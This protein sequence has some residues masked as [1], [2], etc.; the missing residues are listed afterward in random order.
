MLRFVAIEGEVWFNKKKKTKKQKNP[1]QGFGGRMGSVIGI[2]IAFG[3]PTS[4]RTSPRGSDDVVR[5]VEPTTYHK[6]CIFCGPN[7]VVA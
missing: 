6:N 4:G 2:V 7:V 5:R 1:K 3:A